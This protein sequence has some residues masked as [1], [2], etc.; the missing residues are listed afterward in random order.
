MQ[1]PRF[2][3]PHLP[4]APASCGS[5]VRT[6]DA[7]TPSSPMI[8]AQS[9]QLPL[10]SL[11]SGGNGIRNKAATPSHYLSSE[12][13][14]QI[15]VG[16]NSTSGSS[17]STAY[18]T[19]VS[20][21]S[22]DASVWS[23]K[24]STVSETS[25]ARLVGAPFDMPRASVLARRG[26][27]ER[28]A[29][30]S[31][32]RGTGGTRHRRGSSPDVREIQNLKRSLSPSL[33]LSQRSVLSSSTSG[34][35]SKQ[36]SSCK[37]L[38]GVAAFA[39]TPPG[40]ASASSPASRPGPVEVSSA[41]QAA[42]VAKSLPSEARQLKR[43][44]SKSPTRGGL[45][46]KLPVSPLLPRSRSIQRADQRHGSKSIT[47]RSPSPRI[48]SAQAEVPLGLASQ[49]SPPLK[50]VEEHLPENSAPVSRRQQAL[51]MVLR[52]MED[53]VRGLY[54]R[55]STLPAS[56]DT[57]ISHAAS[58]KQS[59][60]DAA[61][62]GAAPLEGLSITSSAARTSSAASGKSSVAGQSGQAL[63][64]AGA[65]STLSSQESLHSSSEASGPSVQVSVALRRSTPTHPSR[66]QSAVLVEQSGRLRNAHSLGRV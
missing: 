66:W 62:E 11:R 61:G 14:Y 32:S 51:T 3:W 53:S 39:W 43:C 31:P 58:Q 49:A 37:E 59:L 65:T 17:A 46:Y 50:R 35:T 40:G 19:P 4:V 54:C 1:T 60:V 8:S 25:A 52:N 22:C 16:G 41:D 44:S 20:R 48:P 64:H 33:R 36:S 23:A 7:S 34:V 45:S 26:N 6:V 38:A 13:R 27:W 29:S 12:Q 55:P 56:D 30:R 2:A 9:V 5:S 28:A 15:E 24:D 42:G 18:P 21:A 10:G 47:A 63:R 57:I